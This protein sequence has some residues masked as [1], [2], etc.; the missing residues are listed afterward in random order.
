LI[1]YSL[2]VVFGEALRATLPSQSLR[3][4]RM[5][6]LPQRCKNKPPKPAKRRQIS[7]A[8]ES[9]EL[10]G[11]TDAQRMRIVAKLSRLLMLAAGAALTESD[12]ER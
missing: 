5:T 10:L 7:I 11:L 2:R 6:E 4:S 12:D 9:T 1:D 3:R 8:F